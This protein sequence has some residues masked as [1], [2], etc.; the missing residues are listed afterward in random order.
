MRPRTRRRALVALTA[1]SIAAGSAVAAASSSNVAVA[2]L[3]RSRVAAVKQQDGGIPV[4]LPTTMA[5]GSPDYTAS[6]ASHSSYKLEIA[7][8]KNCDTANVCLL[9]FFEGRRGG[10]RFGKPVEL[11]QGIEGAFATIQCGAACSP[12]SIDWIESGVLYTIQANPAIEEKPNVPPKAFE[13][14]FIEAADQAI[15]AGPR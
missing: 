7:A 5:L 2:H 1:M 4:L 9:A 11:A 15:E 3:L 6:S 13:E 12:A 10:K 14:V 8:A